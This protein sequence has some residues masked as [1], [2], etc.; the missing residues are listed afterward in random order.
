M[1][2]CGAHACCIGTRA[3][4]CADDASGTG[5]FRFGGFVRARREASEARL[6]IFGHF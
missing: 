4:C 3:C 6:G 1:D 2:R 5:I